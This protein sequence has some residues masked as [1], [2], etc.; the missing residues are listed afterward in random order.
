MRRSASLQMVMMSSVLVLGL[1]A[2]SFSA[3][4]KGGNCQ[5]KLAGNSYDCAYKR[6]QLIAWTSIRWGTLRTST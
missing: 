5:A 3:E 4:A 6:M 1:L 2:N